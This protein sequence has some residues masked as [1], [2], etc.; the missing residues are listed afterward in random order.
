MPRKPCSYCFDRYLD[1]EECAIYLKKIED[2]IAA[3]IDVE[4][5]YQARFPM[6]V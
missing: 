2:V 5:W 4:A 1:H 6:E 3:V